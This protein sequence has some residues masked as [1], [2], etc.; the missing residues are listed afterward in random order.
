MNTTLQN[1]CQIAIPFASACAV[2]YVQDILDS[3]FRLIQ[4]YIH[5]VAAGEP[6]TQAIWP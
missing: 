6:F 2:R 1:C 3:N 4:A 5:K